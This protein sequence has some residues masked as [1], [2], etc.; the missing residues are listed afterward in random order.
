MEERI[1]KFLIAAVVCWIVMP[2]MLF[3]FSILFSILFIGLAIGLAI[4]P[5]VALIKPDVV[6]IN[7]R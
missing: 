7:G 5:V 1:S 3:L 4:L 2:I 6:K